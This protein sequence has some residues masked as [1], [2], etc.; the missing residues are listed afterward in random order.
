KI[1]Y[2]TNLTTWT[3]LA[4]VLNKLITGNFNGDLYAD[5]AGLTSAGQIY[6]TTDHHTWIH[7]PG[8]LDRLAGDPNDP[9]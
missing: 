8:L 9:D 4:G 6:Y 5:L 1:Y 7:I 2:T 3:Y